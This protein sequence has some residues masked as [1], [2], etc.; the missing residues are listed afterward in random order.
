MTQILEMVFRTGQG[1][2]HRITLD[3]PRIDILPEDVLSTMNLILEANPFDIEGGLVD[4][5]EANIITTQVQSIEL[6]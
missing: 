4:I 1:R 6:A 5:V 2:N 3:D